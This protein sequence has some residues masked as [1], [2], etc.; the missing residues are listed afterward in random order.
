[1]SINQRGTGL[2]FPLTAYGHQAEGS[3]A[4]TADH[5]LKRSFLLALHE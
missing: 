2:S 4:V 3:L 5:M 1:M